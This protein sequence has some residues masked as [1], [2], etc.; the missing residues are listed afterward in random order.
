ML[1][2]PVSVHT[3]DSITGTIVLRRNP[4]WRRHMTVTLRWNINSS[5]GDAGDGQASFP[6]CS[7]Y[8]RGGATLCH[9]PVEVLTLMQCDVHQPPRS[10]GTAPFNKWC[11]FTCVHRLGQRLSPCGDDTHSLSQQTGGV[12]DK[13]FRRF[14][15]AHADCQERDHLAGLT[16]GPDNYSRTRTA[17]QEQNNQE[18]GSLLELDLNAHWK[19]RLYRRNV[20][21]W[22]FVGTLLGRFTVHTARRA[23][24]ANALVWL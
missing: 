17:W 6:S 15:S 18:E 11:P 16:A 22:I 4:V 12:T 7:L 5:P 21:H 14:R 10:P 20:L 23:T 19:I 1:D 3:G 9:H 24:L 13:C 8:Y 2:S